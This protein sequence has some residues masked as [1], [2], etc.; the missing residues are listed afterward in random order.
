M[1]SGGWS[2]EVW[3]LGR[4]KEGQMIKLFRTTKTKTTEIKSSPNEA[5]IRHLPTLKTVDRLCVDGASTV[6]GLG[7]VRGAGRFQCDW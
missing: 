4:E 7:S 3:G 6:G 5:R 2:G 1:R